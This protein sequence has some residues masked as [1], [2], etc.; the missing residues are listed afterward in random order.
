MDFDACFFCGEPIDG[1]TS[2]EHIFSDKFLEYLGLK[3][4]KVT[5]SLPRST[6]YSKVKVPAHSSCNS[7]RG[8][9]FEAYILRLIKSMDANLAHLSAIHTAFGEPLNE[10][11]RHAFTQWLAKLYYGLLYW[12]AGLETHVDPDYQRW[13]GSLL[14]EPEFAYLRKCFVDQLAFKIPSSLFHFHVPDPPEPAFRFDF[15]NGLPHGL[16]YVRFRNHLLVTALAD[17]NL[18][19]QWLNEEHVSSLQLSITQLSAQDPAEYLHAVAHIWAIRELLPV[20]PRLEYQDRDILDRSRE[21]YSQCPAID[22]EAVNSR[23]AEL[24]QKLVAKWKGTAA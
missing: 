21:G 9:E 8:S 7:G 15:G 16:F 6:S 24:F 11:L 1:K 3:Q 22:S 13:L 14:A 19:H 18:V 5:S 12:E 4:E 2:R 20:A 17:A 10:S 23:A